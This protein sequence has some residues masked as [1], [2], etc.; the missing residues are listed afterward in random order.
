MKTYLNYIE[1]FTNCNI[2]ES[3]D[4]DIINLFINESHIKNVT[5]YFDFI[6]YPKYLFFFYKDMFIANYYTRILIS[7]NQ[8][9][10]YNIMKLTK[11]KNGAEFSK[12]MKSVFNNK[13]ISIVST[14][15][16]STMDTFK[17]HFNI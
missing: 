5:I 15:Y 7:L 4:N 13:N 6:E 2:K 9:I 11:I 3:L 10:Y 1:K 12:L 17:K 8:H 16:D 14:E